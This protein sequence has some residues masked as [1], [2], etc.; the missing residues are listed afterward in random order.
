MNSFYLN[1][2]QLDQAEL[3]RLIEVIRNL[4]LS[5]YSLVLMEFK[6]EG[7]PVVNSHLGLQERI[8]W[9]KSGQVL[10]GLIE[11]SGIT[12][13]ALIEGHCYYEYAEL[14][15]ATHKVICNE[16]SKLKLAPNGVCY[17]PRWGSLKRI[18]RTQPIKTTV[19]QILRGENDLLFE[20]IKSKINL[21]V[22]SKNG[23]DAEI[24]KVKDS[25]NVV[26][27]QLVRL[28]LVGLAGNPLDR[29]RL[30]YYETSFFVSQGSLLSDEKVS[31]LPQEELMSLGFE[32]KLVKDY[33]DS[34]IDYDPYSSDP[35]HELIQ[36]RNR[37]WFEEVECLMEQNLAPI[38]GHC[39]EIGSGPGWLSCMI[40]KSKR[41]ESVVAFDLSMVSIIRW[42]PAYWDAI[43]PDWEKLSYRIGDIM[44]LPRD[45]VGKFDTVIFGASLHHIPDYKKA[46]RHAYELLVP[47]GSLILQGEHYHT[48]LLSPKPRSTTMPDTPPAFCRA[49]RNAG[50]RPI[51]FRYALKGRR[52][53]R[54]K[55]FVMT[56][57]PFKYINGYVGIFQYMVLGVKPT[58]H[59]PY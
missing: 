38:H 20:S 53:P 47:G 25:Q 11:N 28:A 58:K 59:K 35:D 2:N 22:V 23:L 45:M 37:R 10:T 16:G 54:F 12:F 17:F 48:V 6:C 49:V 13:V 21:V 5:N 43:N 26:S 4:K 15:L 19:M 30:D 52:F 32:T 18:Q 55:K 8:E 9:S 27:P 44:N 34:Q 40:S 14:A 7:G 36:T 33:A 50:F 41:V 31:F 56:T 51:V 1:V 39:L 3:S 46:L 24:S 29:D 42:G 57:W